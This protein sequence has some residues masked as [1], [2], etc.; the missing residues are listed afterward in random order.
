MKVDESV[1]IDNLEKKNSFMSNTGNDERH[2]SSFKEK[3]PSPF[4]GNKKVSFSNQLIVVYKDQKIET[5]PPSHFSKKK[6]K[7]GCCGGLLK[8]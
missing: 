4:K 3:S 2:K 6:T 5:T 7:K 1:K 8:I